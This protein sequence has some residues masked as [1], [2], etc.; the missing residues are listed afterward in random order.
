MRDESVTTLLSSFNIIRI[1]MM[2][3]KLMEYIY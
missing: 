2:I 3:T 1:Y